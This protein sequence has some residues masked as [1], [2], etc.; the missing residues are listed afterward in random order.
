VF[1]GWAT[2]TSRRDVRDIKLSLATRAGTWSRPTTVH[3]DHFLLHH[4]PSVGP[5]A[6]VDTRGVTHLVWWTG[7]AGRAGY[8]YATRDV[9]GRYSEPILVER[10]LSAPS[11]NNSTLALDGRGRVWTATV[12]HGEYDA[13]G[14]ADTSPNRITVYAIT[15][16]RRVHRVADAAVSGAYPQLVTVRGDVAQVWIDRG[17]ILG[18]RLGVS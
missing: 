14:K 13:S 7:A 11:E 9:A 6:V 12:G 1:R 17:K 2:G 3:N 4:C 10:H 18:R 8:W 5:V 15:A 16:D